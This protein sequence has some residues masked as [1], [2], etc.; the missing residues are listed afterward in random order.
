[1]RKN[2]K[3]SLLQVVRFL[4]QII[5]FII[6]PGIYIN[7]FAGIKQIY[8]GIINQSFS[9]AGNL[10]QLVEVIAVIPVTII[11]GRFFCGWM[12]A[13]GTLGDVLYHISSKVFKVR[14]KVN[15]KF[16]G[17]FKYFKFV[18][19]AFLIAVVWTFNL[20]MF[21]GAN[22]WDAFGVIAAFGKVPDISYALT[23]FTIGT[24]LLLAIIAA[25]LFIE[26]F[27]CRY[28]CPLGA[29]FAVVSKLR[30]VK[31]KRPAEKC[32]SCRI[33]SN[34]CVMGIPLYKYDKISSGECIQCFKCV[35]VCPRNNTSVDIGK[36]NINTGV[37]AAL[38]VT[39]M[40]GLYYGGSFISGSADTALVSSE[41]TEKE[42]ESKIYAD[43]TYEGSGTGFRGAITTV[44]VT[45]E[46]DAIK[47][48]E[49]LSHGDD[50]PYFN[51]AYKYVAN[52]IV[53]SQ[54]ADVD[55]VSGATYS[56]VGIMDAVQDAMNK[57]KLSLKTA[58]SDVSQKLVEEPNTI[59]E[60]AVGQ[61][62]P[63][64]T[65]AEEPSAIVSSS[66]QTSNTQS[67][68][69][70][71]QPKAANTQPKATSSQPKA[72]NTKHKETSTKPK[73]ANTQ[74]KATSTQA[75]VSESTPAENSSSKYKDG[76]YEGSAR[77]FRRG[78]TKVSIVIKNDEIT[79]IEILS[80][81][82]DA[83]FFNSAVSVIG[84]MLETQSTDV[85]AVSGATYSSMG[86]MNAVQA[87]LDQARIG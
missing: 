61:F 32:G 81:G 84:E 13:F 65:V 83:P 76:T 64:P 54:Y 18:L 57:A 20:S 70:S 43:G 9:F 50:A 59:Q 51:R 38:A 6:L 79:D 30:F 74:P 19:L 26:R 42:S 27:F 56:S 47:D 40:T 67:E 52:Q 46:K 29:I 16:D 77:G 71:T 62:T 69:T 25:S 78:I 55:A 17:V 86:I 44:S 39:C 72:A 36:E 15:E 58:S 31:I 63:S 34:S 10:P 2:K 28:L 4:I 5:F 75:K 87:A 37:A 11:F 12:C 82:D 23:E 1:M 22:P 60:S 33:C 41:N 80:H 45:I 24:L 3:Y 66:G 14:F 35:S 68:A 48:I 53:N 7:A 49:V 8:L 85:D 21:K 73:T